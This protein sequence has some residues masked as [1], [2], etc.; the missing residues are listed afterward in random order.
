MFVVSKI[1]GFFAIPS[2]LIM[3]MGLFGALLLR[4]SFA[5]AGRRLVIA[6]LILLT[7][8]GFSPIGN[9]LIL[10]LEQRFPAW[11][12]S[13]G[14]PDGI[15]VLGGAVTPDVSL[16]RNDV[17]L[18]EAAERMTA[19]VELARRYP[20]ARIIFSGGDASIAYSGNEAEAALRLL[21]RL[22]L[23]PGRVEAE[24]QSRNTV[25]NAVFSKRLAAPKPGER[26]LLVT[27]AYHTPRAMGIFRTAGFLVEAYPVDWRTRGAQDAL[28]PFPTLADGLRRT[29]TA[30]RE[31]AGLV[32]Y[33]LT[34]R[35]SELFPAP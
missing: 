11:D 13:R 21:E 35:S 30:V 3:L 24:D 6:C 31:W 8:V 14:A 32:V 17:A 28:R 29:D 25:E 9:V 12:A 19:T 23:P 27:S 18:N 5:R 7:F 2:N 20:N 10:P 22:G 33:H 34:G 4:T 15:V 16:A 1:A 26:W